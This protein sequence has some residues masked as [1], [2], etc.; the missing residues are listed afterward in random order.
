[1][2]GIEAAAEWTELLACRD[3]ITLGSGL[4]G[5]SSYTLTTGFPARLSFRNETAGLEERL[6]FGTEG[7]S[8]DFQ[9]CS[10]TVLMVGT[11]G[12]VAAWVGG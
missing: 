1:M 12:A 2:V 4:V 5:G 11:A 8:T 10:P 7:G 9:D 3:C 6:S